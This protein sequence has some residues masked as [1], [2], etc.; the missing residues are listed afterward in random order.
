M[1]KIKQQYS[2]EKKMQTFSFDFR[3]RGKPE[4]DSVSSS[5]F[6]GVGSISQYEPYTATH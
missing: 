2:A 3:L 4:L 5:S 1:T 6:K